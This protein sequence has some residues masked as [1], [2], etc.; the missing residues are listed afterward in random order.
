M[1]LEHFLAK[2]IIG[3]ALMTQKN[4]EKP[5]L[6]IGFPQI[7]WPQMNISLMPVV[8]AIGKRQFLHNFNFLESGYTFG[9]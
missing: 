2:G 1:L 5:E 6:H 8:L 7:V 9:I 3:K 4:L